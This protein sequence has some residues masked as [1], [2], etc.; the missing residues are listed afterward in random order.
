MIKVSEGKYYYFHIIDEK[1]EFSPDNQAPG[2]LQNP[3]SG[4]QVQH[5]SVVMDVIISQVDT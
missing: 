3:V 1:N 4:Y 2:P 5:H